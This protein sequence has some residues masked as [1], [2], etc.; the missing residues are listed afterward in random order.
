SS[1]LSDLKCVEIGAR[2][3]RLVVK[4]LFEMRDVPVA[5]NG[6]AM[7]STADVIVDSARSHFSQRD[8]VHLQRV[9]PALAFGIA[10]VKSGQKIE[11]D[12]SRKFRRHAKP[13][14]AR[15]KTAIE[16]LVS[17]LKDIAVDLGSCVRLG[18]L[19]F[20]QRVDDFGSAL[21]NF[22]VVLFPRGRDSL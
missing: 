7:K 15:I 8:E 6:V 13:A 10:R 19:R 22:F 21:H 2:K 12:G 5:V 17:V 9:L 14:L 18:G 4:H 1:I 16:L 20:A 11:R 3:L